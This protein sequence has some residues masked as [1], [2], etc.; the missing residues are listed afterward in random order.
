MGILLQSAHILEER[1]SILKKLIE[2][3][4]PSGF[5]QQIQSYIRMEIE[6]YVDIM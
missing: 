6:K 3:P 4:S 1:L 5:E 2:T